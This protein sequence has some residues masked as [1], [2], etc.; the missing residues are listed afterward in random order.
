MELLIL[1]IFLTISLSFLCSILEA[2]LLSINTTFIKIELKEGK[3]YAKNLSD[4]KNSIDEPLIII[5]TLNTIAH[6]VGAILVGV[7]AKVAYSELNLKNN[8]FAS[9]ISDE[10]LV[11]FVSTVMTIMILLFSEIIPKTIGAKYWNKLAGFTTVF[12]SSI[13]PIFKYTGV[14]WILQAFTKSIGAS[15][16]ELFLKREDISTIAEIAKEEGIIEEKDSKFI[17]NIVK[18]RNVSVKEIMTPYSVMVTAD[19]NLTIN[20][21][22]KKNPELIFSRIPILNN[23][24]IEAYVLKD[25]ILESIINEKGGFKLKDIKRP[26]IISAENTKIPKLF[27]KLLKKR[28]HISLVIDSSKNTTGIVTLEDIIETILGYEI[29][30]E[31]DMVDDMQLLAKKISSNSDN[32]I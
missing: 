27:D 18:L 22:Y 17:K 24:K 32:D 2:V 3:K 19:E 8:F 1:Y 10:F 30:D 12:L 28:E 23:K 29:V 5:L 11:G 13:I 25:T 21:F 20:E 4:L 31:T 7:Q 15:K 14:L 16:K 26:I 6:T 9:G